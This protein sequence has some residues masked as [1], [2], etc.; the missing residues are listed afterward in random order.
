MKTRI[1]KIA[2]LPLAIRE[3]LNHRLLN[4]E[5][6]APLLN[7]LNA[8]PEVQQIVPGLFD[9]KPINKQNLSDWRQGGYQD[10]LRHQERRERFQQISENGE[11]L[12]QLE[13]Y[14]LLEDFSRL[15][16]AELGDVLAELQT[17]T[18]RKQRWQKLQELSRELTRLQNGYNYSRWVDL[19]WTKLNNQIE[20]RGAKET[21][22]ASQA[23]STPCPL[24]IAKPE[25]LKPPRIQRIVH[26]RRCG[27]ECV[28]KDCHSDNSKYPYSEVQKDLQSAKEIHSDFFTR[29]GKDYYLIRGYCNCYCGCEK[30]LA[31]QQK[32]KTAA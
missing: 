31:R 10:W 28:C 30:S 18:D 13:G 2:R 19:A 12:A 4:G 25:P 16:I 17:I 32:E 9:A 22:K 6:G 1:G 20:N 5:M 23:G 14:D 27:Y 15:L 11:D 8:L 3:Q 21:V 29:D 24:P 26:H 7:W